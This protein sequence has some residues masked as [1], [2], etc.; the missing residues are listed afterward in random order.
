MKKWGGKIAIFLAWLA[1]V[2]LGFWI[3]VVLHNMLLTILAAWYVGESVVRSWRARALNQFY[4]PISGLIYLIFIFAVDGYLR[5][6][7][8]K[9]DLIRRF[10]KVTAIEL[11]I[12]FPADLLISLAEQSIF[13]R[14]SLLLIAL[15]LVGGVG[16]LVYA[17]LK[18]P[19][20]KKRFSK[21]E[22][23]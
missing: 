11:L 22:N 6:G 7:L 15:E 16:L 9:R 18:D 14:S 17:I 10:V 12:L 3:L 1:N 5:A 4:F 21:R 8:E 2:A 13:E 20:R 19:K 23:V